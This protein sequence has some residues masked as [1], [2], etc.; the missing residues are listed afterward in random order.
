MKPFEF[1]AGAQ[2]WQAGTLLHWYVEAEWTNPRHQPLS[3][4]VT[5]SN[6]ALVKAGFPITPVELKRLHIT[7]S[8]NRSS[9]ES[10]VNRVTWSL[11]C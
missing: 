6:Q 8:I 7:L 3:D 5:D 1:K 2:P 9:E 11:A 4:L 10:Q